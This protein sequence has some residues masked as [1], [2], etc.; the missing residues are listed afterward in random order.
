MAGSWIITRLQDKDVANFRQTEVLSFC[1]DSMRFKSQA[2]LDE[3]AIG[4]CM[5]YVDL[6]PIRAGVAE[7]RE[8]SDFTSIQERIRENRSPGDA[9]RF[10][11]F[12]RISGR[13]P[14]SRCSTEAL[15]GS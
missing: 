8:E 13:L 2:L 1:I 3:A 12:V 5:A 14:S 7:T 4:S 9:H 15:S 10:S 11:L 6:N